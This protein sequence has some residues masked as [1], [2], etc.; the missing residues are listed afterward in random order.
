MQFGLS[1]C[2]LFENIY[3]DPTVYVSAAIL[4]TTAPSNMLSSFHVA[5]VVVAL[6]I[7]YNYTVHQVVSHSLLFIYCV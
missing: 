4:Q 7:V 5:P 6:S 1:A 2:K 3:K